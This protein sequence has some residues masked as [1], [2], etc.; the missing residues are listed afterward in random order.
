MIC[1]GCETEL[2]DT[3]KTCPKCQLD[4]EIVSEQT[5]AHAERINDIL[6]KRKNAKQDAEKKAALEL[7]K[8]KKKPSFFAGL[9][10]KA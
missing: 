8:S 2:A 3:E 9:G 10:K 4:L 5:L 7:E 1:P 6:A